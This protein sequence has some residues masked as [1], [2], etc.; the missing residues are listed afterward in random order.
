MATPPKQPDTFAL[1]TLIR[2]MLD[3]HPLIAKCK[4]TNEVLELI[5]VEKNRRIKELE[6]QLES[7][8]HT[9]HEALSAAQETIADLR[10][11]IDLLE[12]GEQQIVNQGEP[13][14]PLDGSEGSLSNPVDVE[15]ETSERD[16]KRRKSPTLD[17]QVPIALPPLYQ[18]AKPSPSVQQLEQASQHSRAA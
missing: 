13:K 9:S 14:R 4:E 8:A 5:I 10:A 11:H 17:Q 15:S 12:R 3:E 2:D 16:A 7:Q 6:S 18:Q 1:K